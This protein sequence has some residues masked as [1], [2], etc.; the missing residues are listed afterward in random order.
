MHFSLDSQFS[1][2][3]ARLLT[4][5]ILL[6]I[7]DMSQLNRAVTVSTPG[8]VLV[9]GG[10]MVLQE[11]NSLVFSTTSRFYSSIKKPIVT[12]AD[13]N[14]CSFRVK[15][16]SPQFQAAWVYLCSW[17]LTPQ[18]QVFDFTF[19]EVAEESKGSNVFAS[20][21]IFYALATAA[22]LPNRSIVTP[23]N[24]ELEVTVQ[25]DNDFY[26]QSKAVRLSSYLQNNS[27]TPP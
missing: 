12:A 6:G 13:G 3:P 20:N 24:Y 19:S 2:Y 14:R 22:C 25:A 5:V 27:D 11:G 21:A 10:Y 15:V 4:L 18:R 7:E 26:S 16:V 1:L 8:K 23:G 17:S 9:C